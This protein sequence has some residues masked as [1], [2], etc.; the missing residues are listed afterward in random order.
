[1]FRR[2]FDGI[3]GENMA[4]IRQIKDS[5]KAEIEMKNRATGEMFRQAKSFP[6]RREAEEWAAGIETDLRRAVHDDRRVLDAVTLAELITRYIEEVSPVKLGSKQEIVRLKRWLTHPLAL[7]PVSRCLA[8][9]FASY[10]AQRR[11]DTSARGGRVS[12]QTIKHEI[13]CISNVF[14]T[15]RKDWGYTTLQNPTKQISKPGGSIARET[16]IGD[17]LDALLDELRKCRNA[18]YSIITEFAVE[19]GLR[20]DEL[21]RMTWRDIDKVDRVV[22]V[23]GKD[24]MSRSGQRKK[25]IVPLSQRAIELLAG[26]P[27]SINSDSLVFQTAGK[28]SA[29][30][31]SRAFTAAAKKVGLSDAVFHSTRHEAASRMAPYYPLVTLMSVM[32]W[33][34]PSMAARYYHASTDELHEGLARMQNA[35][36]S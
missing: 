1:M 34:T 19:T 17:K 18:Q 23:L 14:E 13:I 9:D 33:K 22:S 31:L 24:T 16:R 4:N 26:L 10:I 11:K 35:C 12:E 36:N 2:D 3:D 5:F 21:F 6:T 32:G 27:Q 25:R 28:T 30:G 20:Q 29:D 8:V 7:R 15:A